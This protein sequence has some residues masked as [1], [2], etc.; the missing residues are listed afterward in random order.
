MLFLSHELF[1][2]DGKTKGHSITSLADTEGT[3]Y[4]L[5][6]ARMEYVVDAKPQFL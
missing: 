6:G 3:I 2:N 4:S 5:L 1:Y